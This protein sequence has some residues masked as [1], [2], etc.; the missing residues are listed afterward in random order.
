[1]SRGQVFNG[2]GTTPAYDHHLQRY[3][4]VDTTSDHLVS[5]ADY[6][7]RQE[8]N[9]AHASHVNGHVA[10]IGDESVF[11]N[12]GF[13]TEQSSMYSNHWELS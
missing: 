12:N 7:G 2:S 3:H 6:V 1:M 9:S 5:R 4:H 10:T 8:D 13:N 11:V